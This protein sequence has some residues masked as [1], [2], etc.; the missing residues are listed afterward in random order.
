MHPG[1]QL[2]FSVH[3]ELYLCVPQK[4]KKDLDIKQA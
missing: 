4:E 2:H 1:A 3:Y